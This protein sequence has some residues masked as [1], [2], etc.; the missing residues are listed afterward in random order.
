MLP[1]SSPLLLLVSAGGLL[2]VHA[3]IMLGGAMREAAVAFCAFALMIGSPIAIL[4]WF[5]SLFDLDEKRR[6][7]HRQLKN[8]KSEAL[9]WK[10]TLLELQ[11]SAWPPQH[12]PVLSGSG[13]IGSDGRPASHRAFARVAA[14]L[15]RWFR[16]GK[17]VKRPILAL[18]LAIASTI[19]IAGCG[20]PPEAWAMV[21]PG[22]G[23]AELV[24]LV[25]GPDYI[26]SNG[27]A[28]VWQ[29]CR[30]FPGRD[31]GRYARYYT[32]VLVDRQQVREVRP[33]PVFSAAGCEDFYRAE[34]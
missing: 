28:E 12:R 16:E 18:C 19:G 6:A 26:R 7:R 33:Y 34:F 25:G 9:L 17:R 21:R 11:P 14:A 22:M 15:A 2:A 30:D 31:E 27:T 24:A 4:A 20:V 3:C 5:G 32:A 29:Y 8:E 13:L 23:T 1:R 10:R